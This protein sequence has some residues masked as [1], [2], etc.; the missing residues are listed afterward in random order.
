MV[1]KS[2]LAG[3]F[4][5]RTEILLSLRLCYLFYLKIKSLLLD[6]T[7]LQFQPFGKTKNSKLSVYLKFQLTTDKKLAGTHLTVL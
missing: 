4:S 2:G 5:D 3:E 6:L 1:V 7:N